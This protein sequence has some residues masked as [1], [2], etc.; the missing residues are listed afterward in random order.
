MLEMVAIS[1]HAVD[2]GNCC[3]FLVDKKFTA[4]GTHASAQ[5]TSLLAAMTSDPGSY[6]SDIQCHTYLWSEGD[7][8][9]SGGGGG[10][11]RLDSVK[12]LSLKSKACTPAIFRYSSSTILHGTSHTL[13]LILMQEY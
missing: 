1:R 11:R 6:H 13:V 4:A 3:Q 12:D 5:L 7:T 2:V 10:G 9:Q 8:G